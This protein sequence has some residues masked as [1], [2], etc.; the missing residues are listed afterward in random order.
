MPLVNARRGPGLLDFEGSGAVDFR[1]DFAGIGRERVAG[2]GVPGP[3]SLAWYAV[4]AGNI[5]SNIIIIYIGHRTLFFCPALTVNTPKRLVS[6]LGHRGT[7]LEPCAPGERATGARSPRLRG[8][9]A[10]DF[11]RDFAG[12]GRE[13]VAEDGAPGAFMKTKISGA[14][15][16]CKRTRLDINIINY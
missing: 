15:C 12:I 4:S 10:V 3:C 9:G 13:R 8:V 11:R 14:G 5:R 1:R 2:D 16:C 7:C 6:F